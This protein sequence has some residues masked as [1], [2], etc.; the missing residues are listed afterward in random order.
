MS[1]DQLASTAS[2]IKPQTKG[3]LTSTPIIGAQLFADHSLSPPFLNCQLLKSFS[4]DETV[5]AK[6]G[7]ERMAASYNL[8]IHHCRADN[9]RFADD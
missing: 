4:G 8:P 3:N 1:I 5:R 7:F 6:V 9:D 2:G